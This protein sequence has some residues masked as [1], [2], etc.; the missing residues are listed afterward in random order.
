MQRTPLPGL[1]HSGTALPPAGQ[2]PL[3]Q[4]APLDA[5]S[6]SSPALLLKRLLRAWPAAVS[7]IVLVVMVSAA[8]LAPWI[9]STD[10]DRGDL[11]ARLQPPSPEY[12]LG[13]DEQGRDMLTRVIYGSRIAL[14]VGGVATLI[15]LVVGVAMGLVSGYYGGFVDALI[16]RVTDIL[17]AFPYIL[18][19]IAIVSI[20]GPSI[21]NAMIAIGIRIVPE[22][23]RLVRAVVL[24][25]RTREYV[26]AARSV[27]ASNLRI[28]L[29]HILPNCTAPIIVLATLSLAGA[30]LAE[31]SLSFLGLGAQPP[32]PSWGS[33]VAR[34]GPYLVTHPYL[35]IVPGLAIMV[36]VYAL[37][38]FGDWLR[39]VLDP[40]TT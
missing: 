24:S 40:Q 20:L 11:L 21:Y 7:L 38:I 36:V 39:D 14:Q 15:G 27:G 26:L 6:M 25:L 9:T 35:S 28:I 34:G 33:M 31:A 23:A 2:V 16:M 17:L 13:T 29:R 12:L 22:F 30:I 37:N 5:V 19:V 32:A 3:P 8:V 18:L 1:Q 4:G 10:P